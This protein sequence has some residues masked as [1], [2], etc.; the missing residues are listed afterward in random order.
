[1]CLAKK[2]L[3]VG[4]DDSKTPTR[5]GYYFMWIHPVIRIDIV[6]QLLQ[7]NRVHYSRCQ[8]RYK[9]TAASARV[10]ASC[11][12]MPPFFPLMIPAFTSAEADA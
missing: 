4:D 1:M 6:Y 12:A 10:V 11:G 3:L 7:F 2:P 9:I 8:M 5:S